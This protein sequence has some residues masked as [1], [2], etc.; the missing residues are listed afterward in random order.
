MASG[1]FVKY[2][3]NTGNSEIF[4][5][6]FY[7]R[8]YASAVLAMALFMCVC[9]S[10]CVSHKWEVYKKMAKRIELVSGVEASFHL[11]YTVL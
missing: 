8:R 5:R 9:M 4:C 6:V 2:Q 1:P 10:V 7:A 3:T 11:S